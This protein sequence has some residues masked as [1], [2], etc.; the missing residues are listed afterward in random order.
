ME[1]AKVNQDINLNDYND[2]WVLAETVNGKILPI[3]L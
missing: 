2:V 1:R 3:T